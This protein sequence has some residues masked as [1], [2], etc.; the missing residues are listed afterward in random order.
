MAVLFLMLWGLKAITIKNMWRYPMST[1]CDSVISFFTDDTTG[2]FHL[3]EL[4]ESAEIDMEPT[5]ARQG[6]GIY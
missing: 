3:S 6:T 2:E 1:H 5:F 4:K